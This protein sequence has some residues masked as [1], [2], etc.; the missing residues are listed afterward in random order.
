MTPAELVALIERHRYTVTCELELQ[1]AIRQVL[2]TAGASFSSEVR[3]SARDRPD[4]MVGTVAIEAKVASWNGQVLRQVT[5]YLE[6]EQ[7]TAL[8]LVTTRRRHRLPSSA[9]GKPILVAL[10]RGS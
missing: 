6:H 10:A 7:V 5:R 1:E 2:T 4:F 3:L 8:V 9:L